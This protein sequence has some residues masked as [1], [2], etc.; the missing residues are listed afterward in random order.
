MVK[1]PLYFHLRNKWLSIQLIPTEEF[2]IFL[3]SSVRW[4][5]TTFPVL[6]PVTDVFYLEVNWTE[7]R[8][9]FVSVT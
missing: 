4:G 6:S 7:V 3:G 1:Q 8:L 2:A 5:K 9:C